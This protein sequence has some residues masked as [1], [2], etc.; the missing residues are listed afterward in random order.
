MPPSTLSQLLSERKIKALI[1]DLDGVITQTAKVHAN[2]WKKMFDDYLLQRGE[3]ESVVYKPLEIATDYRDYIDGIP[4]YDGVRNFLASRNIVLPEG[5]ATDA[6]GKET[7]AGLGNLKNNYFKKLIEQGGVQVYPDTV[8]FLQNKIA[9][10][11]RTAVISASKN[12][13][14]ILAAAGLEELFEVRVDG[15]VSVELGLKGKPAPDVFTEAA[16]QLGVQPQE[17]AIFEDALAGVEAG[18]AGGFALVVG[19]NR[20]DETSEL[21]KHGAD[22]VLDKFPTE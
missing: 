20:T 16:R 13:Q 2:A 5:T 4:R 3:Q 21:L 1:L 19:I 15:V 7:V 17:A 18:K 22:L 9:Q 10:G 6:P 14:P 8:A 11:F 12:C